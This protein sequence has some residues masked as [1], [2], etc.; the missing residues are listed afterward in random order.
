MILR[1]CP[2]ARVTQLEDLKVRHE[3]LLRN[4]D[5]RLREERLVQD[6]LKGESEGYPTAA[7]V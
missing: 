2:Q 5:E 4:A 7:D 6:K 1:C 3:E